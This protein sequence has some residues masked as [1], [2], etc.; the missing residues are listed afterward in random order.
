MNRVRGLVV[1]LVAPGYEVRACRWTAP[2]DLGS[3]DLADL[4]ISAPDEDGLEYYDRD[5]D[6]LDGA[7]ECVAIP[8]REPVP[9]YNRGR[10][11][12]EPRSVS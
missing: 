4:G 10:T 9:H 8:A 1:V 12:I 2:R 6:A 5:G 7:S 3:G 11:F